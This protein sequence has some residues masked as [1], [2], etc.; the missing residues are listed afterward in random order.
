MIEV[1]LSYNVKP[2]IDVQEYY[3]WMKTAIIPTIKSRGM[4]EVRAHRN[5]KENQEVLVVGVWEKLEDWTEFSQNE[6]WK[7]FI[8]P[9]EST[10]ATNVHIEIWGPSPLI[11]APLKPPK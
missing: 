8:T 9:L 11:P 7:S 1:H 5:V 6:G 10:F 3:K 2:D 4:V